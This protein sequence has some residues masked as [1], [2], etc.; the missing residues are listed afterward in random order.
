MTKSTAA[1]A[2]ERRRSIRTYAPEPIGD[3][4]LRELLRLAGRAPSMHNLQPWR[5]VVVRDPAL[6]TALMAAA[7]NQKQVAAAPVA[8]VLYSDVDDVVAHLH[9]LVPDGRTADEAAAWVA[10]RQ[11]YL[12]AMT[13]EART[14]WG[15]AQANIWLGYLLLLAESLGFATSPML[16]FKAQAVKQLLELP[17]SAV[18]TAII[19][20]GR[21]AEEGRPSSRHAVDRVA[22]FR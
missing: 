18:V 22:R 5:V 2:A 6:R 11:D 20:L 21:G 13:P 9:E 1:D 7:N 8:L 10:R 16:G 15:T 4:E 3:E 19:A 17:A 14:A 12:D